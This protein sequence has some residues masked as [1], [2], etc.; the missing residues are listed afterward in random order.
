[1]VGLF[2][3]STSRATCA[4]QHHEKGIFAI[5]SQGTVAGC[6]DTQM[7]HFGPTILRQ[8]FNFDQLGQPGHN[9]L[10]AFIKMRPDGLVVGVQIVPKQLR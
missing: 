10:A 7:K 9:R 4:A 5:I 2:H 1:M 8:S 3:G 6:K